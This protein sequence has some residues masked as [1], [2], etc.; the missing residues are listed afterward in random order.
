VTRAF[1]ALVLS[2]SWADHYAMAA[3][4]LRL[5]GLTPP[6]AKK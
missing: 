2:S 5:N 4:Y 3:M 6:S 1:V